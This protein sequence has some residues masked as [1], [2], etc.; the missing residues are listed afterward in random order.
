MRN[1]RS[2][3]P[4]SIMPGYPFLA[5]TQLDATHIAED[6]R[7]QKLVGVPYT[8]EMIAN[9]RAD[10]EAQA[11]PEADGASFSAMFE[12]LHPVHLSEDGVL[13]RAFG[14]DELTVNSVHYQGIGKLGEGLTVEA[15]APDGLVEAYS[16]RPNNAPLV[17][18]QWHPEWDAD[19][20]PD[21]AAYFHL[22]GKALR[23]EA[24]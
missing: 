21:S 11:R 3:V 24:E 5:Q 15:L 23:G 10:L 12:H 6:M 16:A 8:D 7:T 18:V 19:T 22:L 2:V 1:P 14:K 17:A 13:A 4:T 20:N 9:A